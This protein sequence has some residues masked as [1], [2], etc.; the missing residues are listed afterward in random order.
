MEKVKDTLVELNSLERHFRLAK[1]YMERQRAITKKFNKVL[2][3]D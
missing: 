1:A 3:T 2:G